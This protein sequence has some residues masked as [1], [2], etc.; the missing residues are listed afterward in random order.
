[1][2]IKGR[3]I[4]NYEDVAEYFVSEFDLEISAAVINSIKSLIR[5]HRLYELAATRARFMV[6]MENGN[7]S[8]V[9]YC[10]DAFEFDNVDNIIFDK[11]GII[12]VNIKNENA[13]CFYLKV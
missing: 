7:I 10:K 4:L 12:E 2:I 5:E 11:T 8:D 3:D 1:M 9:I 6:I 13:F